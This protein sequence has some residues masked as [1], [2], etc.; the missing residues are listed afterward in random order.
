MTTKTTISKAA[1]ALGRKGGKS[2]S[3]AK[4]AAVRENGLKGGRPPRY[5]HGGGDIW[6]IRALL[7]VSDIDE[8]DIGY[9]ALC[10]RNGKFFDP[11][12]GRPLLVLDHPTVLH[13]WSD[14]DGRVVAIGTDGV[15][16]KQAWVDALL[17][18]AK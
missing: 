16:T 10:V 13:G 12:D 17:D 9:A 4:A 15:L 2:T 5:R 18:A 8:R 1:A 7:R 6:D 11:L 14:L 3:K